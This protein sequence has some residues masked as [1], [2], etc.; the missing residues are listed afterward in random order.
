MTVQYKRNKMKENKIMYTKLLNRSQHIYAVIMK[1]KKY[2]L[3]L[4]SLFFLHT[5]FYSTPASPLLLSSPSLPPSL[6]PLSS[7]FSYVSFPL[8]FFFL[9]YSL[10]TFPRLISPL[11]PSIFLHTLPLYRS[12]HIYVVTM[13]R[14]SFPHLLRMLRRS[15]WRRHLSTS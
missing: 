11:F 7:S 14:T 4:T 10:S 12:Q 5:C 3:H 13:K 6:L 8:F 1:R 2:H 15:D 9:S